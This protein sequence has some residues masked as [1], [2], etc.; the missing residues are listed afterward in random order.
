VLHLLRAIG[1]VI[2]LTNKQAQNIA[3]RVYNCARTRT[4]FAILDNVIE[5]LS[6]WH[7]LH[8]HENIRRCFDDLVSSGDND[9]DDGGQGGGGQL[10]CVVVVTARVVVATAHVVRV[11]TNAIQFDDMWMP[12]HLQNLNLTSNLGI[13]RLR[14]D[15]LAVQ[16]L[17]RHLM[18]GDLVECHYTYGN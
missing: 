13:H 15:L 7:V 12:K 14:F 8:D 1:C 6:L 9:D 4:Y 10:A 16:Y 18:A 17:D 3:V 2:A 5:Q 11:P